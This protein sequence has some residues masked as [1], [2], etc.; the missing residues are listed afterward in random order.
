M[1]QHQTSEVTGWKAFQKLSMLRKDPI[2]VLMNQFE[3]NGDFFIIK[4][5][6]L[7]I[8]FARDPVLIRYVLMENSSNYKKSLIYKEVERLDGKGLVTSDGQE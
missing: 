7:K 6:G 5:F 4:L 2:R 1:I 8:H 3:E